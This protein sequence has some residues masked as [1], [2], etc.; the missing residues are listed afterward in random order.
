MFR[1]YFRQCRMVKYSCQPQ[2]YGRLNM[3]AGVLFVAFSVATLFAKNPDKLVATV[4]LCLCAAGLFG[5]S[6]YCF[7]FRR[8]PFRRQIVLGS[9][10]N[11]L[12]L[13]NKWLFL[14][15]GICVNL[16]SY[17]V[18]MVIITLLF[19]GTDAMLD[20]LMEKIRGWIVLLVIFLLHTFREFFGFYQYYRSP[21]YRRATAINT[22]AA[23]G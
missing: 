19:D 9:W 1:T 10:Y 12:Y 16:L 3:A 14:L 6:A 20:M 22:G 21:E 18:G 4:I 13:R 8:R 7:R 2:V 11:R 5:Y 23:N 17:L 15:A